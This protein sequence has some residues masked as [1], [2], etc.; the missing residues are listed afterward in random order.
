M[1]ANAMN[2][3]PSWVEYIMAKATEQFKNNKHVKEFYAR[4]QQ[5]QKEMNGTATPAIG[6]D[7]TTKLGSHVAVPTP[8]DL[9]GDSAKAK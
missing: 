4:F 6:T 5:T 9:A 7:P 8:M 2:Q 1:Y 3:L